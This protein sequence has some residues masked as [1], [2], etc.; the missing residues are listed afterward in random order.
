[1]TN[2]EKLDLIEEKIQRVMKMQPLKSRAMRCDINEWRMESG[3]CSKVDEGDLRRYESGIFMSK[4]IDHITLCRSPCF[5]IDEYQT[6]SDLYT[7]L[8]LEL[9]TSK[10]I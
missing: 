6:P 3:M 1:M 5:D 8:S 9:L 7:M 4:I 2:Q 10:L